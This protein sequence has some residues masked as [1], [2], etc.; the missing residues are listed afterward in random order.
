VTAQRVARAAILLL[1]VIAT[2]SGG[3]SPVVAQGLPALKM[4]AA[5]YEMNEDGTGWK[6]VISTADFTRIGSLRLVPDGSRLCFDGIKKDEP[7]S[8][9][10][11]LSCRLDGS[12]LKVHG[13]GAMPNFSPDLKKISYCS[14][15][16]YGVRI[17]SVGDGQDSAVEEGWGVQ[18]CPV[19][20][21]IVYVVNGGSV[22][23]RDVETGERRS[24]FPEGG[25]PY[26]SVFWNMAWSHDGKQLAIQ[27]QRADG[28]KQIAVVDAQGAEF[29][30]SVVCPLKTPSNF[31]AFHPNGR[32]IAFQ[33]YATANK[34]SQLFTVGVEAGSEPKRMSG[35]PEDFDNVSLAW[36]DGGRKVRVVSQQR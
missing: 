17:R 21:Q 11:L 14:Y 23:I 20:N 31:L 22:I 9:A 28:T 16:E 2:I 19:S 26:Q 8:A 32:T 6:K 4:P 10:V 15:A 27:G 33:T 35:Q 12:D 25:S 7:W 30:F 5:I 36:I 1:I 29:K 18:W 34:C 3:A 24:L 13:A